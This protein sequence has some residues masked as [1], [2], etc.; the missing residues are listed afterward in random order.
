MVIVEIDDKSPQ[1]KK[2]VE[3]LNTFEFVNVVHK[4]GSAKSGKHDGKK[5]EEASP[6]NP[7][8]VKMVK[9]SYQEYKA[10]KYVTLTPEYKKKLFGK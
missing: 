4:N 7:E 6:Y 10:G 2:V 3:L 5:A 9:K 1:A 8:F